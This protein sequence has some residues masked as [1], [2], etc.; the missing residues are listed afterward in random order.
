MYKIIVWHNDSVNGTHQA[1]LF[2]AKTI[3]K[4]LR[5]FYRYLTLPVY[6]RSF[7]AHN[8]IQLHHVE[9]GV[10]ANFPASLRG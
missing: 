4:V 9:R 5:D 7:N 3:S 1:V 10:I 8:L 6:C 2:S